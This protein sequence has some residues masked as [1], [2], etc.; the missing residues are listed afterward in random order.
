MRGLDYLDEDDEEPRPFARGSA[1]WEAR[2]AS[3]AMSGKVKKSSGGP[4]P[5]FVP[6]KP[7]ERVPRPTVAD[8]PYADIDRLR[9]ADRQVQHPKN[10]P[11]RNQR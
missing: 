6:A 10:N 5:V 8:G 3:N 7:W 11:K 9:E 1:E 4:K 2:K